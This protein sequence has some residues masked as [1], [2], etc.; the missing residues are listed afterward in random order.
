MCAE[1]EKRNA[2]VMYYNR[3]A[4]LKLGQLHVDEYE[5]RRKINIADNTK[6]Y[7]EYYKNRG[8]LYTE[9]TDC[10]DHYKSS[11]RQYLKYKFL[12]KRQLMKYYKQDI[13][14]IIDKCITRLPNQ[15]IVKQEYQ[16]LDF[17]Y[18]HQWAEID[19][20]SKIENLW[21]ENISHSDRLNNRILQTMNELNCLTESCVPVDFLIDR[22]GKLGFYL[23]PIVQDDFNNTNLSFPVKS[24][25]RDQFDEQM[26]N[27]AGAKLILDISSHE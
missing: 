1:D 24:Y 18:F 10:I 17:P 3:D 11:I 19:F 14:T 16:I 27:D 12:S 6:K 21:V 2:I 9:A 7:I 20:N 5:E 8:E 15:L 25:Y 26:I 4:L 13:P 23:A 22:Y